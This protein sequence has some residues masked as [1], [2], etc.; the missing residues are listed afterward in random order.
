MKDRTE[1]INLVEE[2]TRRAEDG[3]H[4]KIKTEQIYMAD[5]K[6]MMKQTVQSPPKLGDQSTYYREHPFSKLADG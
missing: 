3:K 1:M 5:N 4:S 6:H 2:E